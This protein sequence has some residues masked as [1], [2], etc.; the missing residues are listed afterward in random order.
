MCTNACTSLHPHRDTMHLCL[1]LLA[2]KCTMMWI[3]VHMNCE[4]PW[5]EEE[6]AYAKHALTGQLAW[7]NTIMWLEEEWE[8]N[9]YKSEKTWKGKPASGPTRSKGDTEG[10]PWSGIIRCILGCNLLITP[11]EKTLC[12]RSMNYCFQ[13]LM[14][15]T[16]SFL[17]SRPEQGKIRVISPEACCLTRW[18]PLG[19][20]EQSI[21]AA[22]FS[23][24]RVPVL[25]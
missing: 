10:R 23:Q 18:F 11:K 19:S 6:K 25:L 4:R 20:S 13:L 2:R 24:T 12:C 22:K 21:L 5:L 8:L 3:K 17:T 16:G 9:Q 15:V 1:W 7:G 14:A